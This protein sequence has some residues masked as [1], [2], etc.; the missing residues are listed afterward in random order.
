[1]PFYALGTN[2]ALQAA[3]SM[4]SLPLTS[5]LEEDE[6]EIVL[7]AFC[8]NVRGSNNIPMDPYLILE[9]YG[10]QF[11]DILQDRASKVV[12]RIQQEGQDFV[13]NFL[14][15]HP[16]AIQTKSG[17][18]YLAMTEGTGESPQ[19]TDEVELHYHGTLTDGTVIDSSVER[20]QTVN[21]PLNGVMK[22]WT[23]GL[24]LMKEGGRK[25][26]VM[27][28]ILMCCMLYSNQIGHQPVFSRFISGK[29]TLVISSDLAYGEAGSEAVIPPGTI[30]KFE[31]ELFKVVSSDIDYESDID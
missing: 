18:V 22:G 4:G 31:V 20:G 21:F 10:Q 26:D 9:S 8:A 2:L 1:M 19:V 28:W 5:L 6:L 24:Q 17:L 11:I 12:G 3:G 16:E 7:E 29:A 14:D 27:W 25:C 13:S 23:E 15:C 30:L